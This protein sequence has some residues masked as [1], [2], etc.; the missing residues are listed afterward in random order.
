MQGRSRE[1]PVTFSREEAEEVRRV[2]ATR[3]EPLVCP[4]CG[5]DL[6]LGEAQGGDTMHPV[7]EIRCPPCL[8]SAYVT[9]LAKERRPKPADS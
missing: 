5:A 8:R 1:T 4:R 6:V 7:W 2:A 9:E 3:D